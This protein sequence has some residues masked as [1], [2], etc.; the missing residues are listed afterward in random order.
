MVHYWIRDSSGRMLGPVGRDSVRE[1]LAA[2]R[3][4]GANLVSLDGKSWKPLREFPELV[5]PAGT[6]TAATQ[7]EQRAE[8]VL[9]E[10]KRLKGR[11]PREVLGVPAGA[12]VAQA[13]TAYFSK[14]KQYHPSMLGSKTSPNLRRAYGEMFQILS[15]AMASGFFLPTRKPLPIFQMVDVCLRFK[16]PTREIRGRGRV[17][18]DQTQGPP[19]L[20]PG[21][22]IRL[23]ALS[24]E[25]RRFLQYFAKRAQGVWI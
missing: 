20:L 1:L 15:D 2:N 25:D 12:L 16:V 22:G 4:P 18:C 14:V 10:T 21:Y 6:G 3:L 23:L 13:R 7:E 9:T 11:P 5:P 8:Q 24:D 19:N 17:I